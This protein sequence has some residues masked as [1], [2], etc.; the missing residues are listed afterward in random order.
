MKKVLRASLVFLGL[1]LAL[2]AVA[3]GKRYELRLARPVQAAGTQL[4]AGAYEVEV[5]G[6]SLVFYQKQ[7]EVAK[8]PVR[9]EELQKK[10]DGT[11]LTVTQDKLIS[12]QLNGTKTKLTVEGAQ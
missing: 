2:T 10:N 6:N 12:I 11:S 3:K 5:E 9:S 7:K 1:F 4:S 8:V